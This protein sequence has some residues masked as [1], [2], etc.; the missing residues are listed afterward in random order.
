MLFS[1]SENM[2]Y[3]LTVNFAYAT[4][5]VSKYMDAPTTRFE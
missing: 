3:L 5:I 1:L 2:H 4:I